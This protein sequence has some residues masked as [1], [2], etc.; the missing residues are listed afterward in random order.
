LKEDADFDMGPLMIG[1]KVSG[2]PMEIEVKPG[3]RIDL[4]FTVLNL[5]DTIKVRTKKRNDLNRITG[6]I[7]DAKGKP[8]AGAYAFANRHQSAVTMA[9]YFSAWTEDDGAFSIF[10]PN[11]SY[12]LGAKKTFAPDDKYK[13][14]TKVVVDGDKD[15]VRLVIE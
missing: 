10:L 12:Y 6:I 5:L 2:D 13:A 1:D 7:V 11:G 3:D 8:L 9:G 14:E 4:T 15:G